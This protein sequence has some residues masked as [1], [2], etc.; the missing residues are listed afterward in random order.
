MPGD[1]FLGPTYYQ[2]LKHMVIDKE[3]ARA[4]GPVQ[5]LTRQP[6][7]GRSREGGLRFGEMERDCIISHGAASVLREGPSILNGTVKT[8]PSVSVNGCS[9]DAVRF[10]LRRY[11]V[12]SFLIVEP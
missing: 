9:G 7:E 11:E 10:L 6:V 3:H 4:R 2:R 1:V 12:S 5:I 8:V